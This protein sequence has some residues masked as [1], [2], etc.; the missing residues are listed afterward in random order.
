MTDDRQ[1]QIAFNNPKKR[2]EV[3]E[4]CNFETIENACDMLVEKS[5]SVWG[6]VQIGSRSNGRLFTSGAENTG[7][8]RSTQ[9][10]MQ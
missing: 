5:P 2:N 8:E 6:V 4:M 3:I 10:E 1:I 7:F 9:A